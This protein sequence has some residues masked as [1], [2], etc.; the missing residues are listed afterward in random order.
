MKF[1]IGWSWKITNFEK[2]LGRCEQY[3]DI[4]YCN[5]HK[6]IIHTKCAGFCTV[7]VK[8]YVVY[9]IIVYTKCAGFCTVNVIDYV[10]YSNRLRNSL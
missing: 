10:V 2:I 9:N 3:Y 5:F 6:V 1:W 8:D 4:H 7:Y